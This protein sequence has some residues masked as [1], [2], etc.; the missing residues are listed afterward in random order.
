MIANRLLKN[1]L[2]LS[3]AAA[4]HSAVAVISTVYLARVLG[5]EG[6][7]RISLAFA[8]V[9]FFLILSAMGLDTIGVREVARNKDRV[10]EYA[11]QIITL[12]FFLASLLFIVLVASIPI[13]NRP[14]E[15]NRLLFIYSLVLFPSALFFEW[16]W[17]GLERMGNIGVSKI[18]RQSLYMLFLL[19]L[20]K[21]R[22]DINFVP[23]IFVAVNILYAVILYGIFLKKYGKV[24]LTVNIDSWK[25]LLKNST[26]I[27]V[28]LLLAIMIYSMGTI[29]LGFFR[30]DSEVGYYNAAFQVISFMLMFL[31]VF[32]DALF[33]TISNLY[34][35]SREKMEK[36]LTVSGKIVFLVVAPIT[37]G[38]TVLAPK[39]MDLLF[40]N[41]YNEGVIGLQI[42]MWVICL[43]AANS[44][45]ARGLLAGNM[46]NY[47]LKVVFL[48]TFVLIVLDAILVIPFGIVGATIATLCAE[49]AG[50]YFYWKGFSKIGTVYIHEVAFK[51]LV[52]SLF[53]G[54]FLVAL[55][56]LNLFALMVLGFSIYM[57]TVYMLNVIEKDELKWAVERILN[58]QAPI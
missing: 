25:T 51:T 8:F 35:T 4:V 30:S 39:I 16:T 41:K 18:I 33:P 10:K 22:G 20:V 56:G 49:A 27:G 42:L 58:R 17:Q 26:P 46:Q 13:L 5:P 45:Y 24:R 37:V 40:G 50:L 19:V 55:Q 2:S 52:A 12:K 57:G 14:A 32:F 43:V 36:V 34:L 48:Q 11:G 7:G 9:Q 53:M 44:I 29:F 15:T 28:A 54:A 38:G 3:A 6:F 21:D 31:C 23:V 47:Y 1:F